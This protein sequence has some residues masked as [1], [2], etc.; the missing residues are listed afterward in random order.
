[1][2]DYL[3]DPLF[4]LFVT[5]SSANTDH[6]VELAEGA[7]RAGLDLVAFQDH[8]YLPDLIDTWTLMSFVAA[9]TNRIR[10]VSNVINVP[11]RAPAVLARAA[12]GL[13]ILSHGR[14][15]LGIGAGGFWD[16]IAG[17]GGA[18]RG[19]GEAVAQLN[20][21]ITVIR[22]IWDN[23]KPGTV[24]FD[25]DFYSVPDAKR[26]PRPPHEIGI[27]VGAY[28]PRMLGLTGEAGDGWLPT[29][30]YLPD[31]LA[32]IASSNAIIDDAAVAAG[33]SAQH[34]RRLLNVMNASI[35]PADN[36][37]LQGSIPQWIDQL[38]EAVL[39]YGISG[40]MIGGDNLRIGETLA[41]EIAPAVRENV[42]AA[43][44]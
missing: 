26:G 1:M 28:Q 40:F 22:E 10:I 36:G 2:T 17:M 5:P 4:G 20:E 11:L 34:I 12:A 14:Y 29:F 16:A 25:G 37:F 3:H 27:W 9:R 32:T 43:R 18:R 39:E 35:G 19:P 13:D 33:R 7:D 21:A 41:A 30:E 24:R 8:P 38:T 31:G 6:V 23:E 42:T 44:K 15:E